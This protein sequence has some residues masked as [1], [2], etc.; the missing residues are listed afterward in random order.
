MLPEG[1]SGVRKSG[2]FSDRVGARMNGETQA[3][4]GWA[5][6]ALDLTLLTA[7]AFAITA[8]PIPLHQIGQPLAIAFCL[9]ASCFVA[10][11]FE[12]AVAVVL[13]VSYLFQ[14]MFVAMTSPLPAPYS[15]LDPFKA[16]NF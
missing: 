5:A 3:N 1:P 10:L 9:T 16:Y 8:A 2:G 7:L 11:Y 13:L 15:D 4:E 12:R 14:P 6:R